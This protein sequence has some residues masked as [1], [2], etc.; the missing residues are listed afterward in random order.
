MKKKLV[1]IISVA[2]VLVVI[3][4]AVF[5]GKGNMNGYYV[6]DIGNKHYGL[7]IDGSKATYTT[8][9]PNYSDVTYGTVEKADEG[10]DLYFEYDGTFLKTNLSNFNP[11]HAIPSGDGEHLY[12][13]SDSSD[14]NTDTYRKVSKKEYQEYSKEH[15]EQ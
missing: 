10:V 12:L 15:F 7:I 9:N 5:G 8:D 6:M 4:L 2:V 3:C 14:W 13:S 11:L 1:L